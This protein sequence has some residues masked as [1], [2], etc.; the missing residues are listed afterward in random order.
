MG[1]AAVC[2]PRR[3]FSPESDHN[4]SLILDFQ[5]PELGE[6]VSVVEAIQ[7]VLIFYG[8]PSR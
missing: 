3:E 2:K 8:N 6:N 5:P 7:F 1:K 4:G